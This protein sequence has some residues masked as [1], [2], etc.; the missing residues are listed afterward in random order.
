MRKTRKMMTENKKFPVWNQNAAAYR[1]KGPGLARVLSLAFVLSLILALA[2]PLPAFGVDASRT[3]DPV[4]AVVYASNIRQSGTVTI[5]MTAET[6]QARG[7]RYGDIVNVSF[8]GQTI[9]IPFCSSYGDVPEGSAVLLAIPGE[10]YL[11]LA[12]NGGDFTSTY[13]LAVKSVSGI[14]A[15]SFYWTFSD[16]RRDSAVITI[17]LEAAGLYL[18]GYYS[19]IPL[20]ISKI[21]EDFPDLTDAQFANFRPVTTTG[22]GRGVLYRTSSPVDPQNWRNTYADAE[23]RKAGVTVVLNLADSQGMISE[24]P[25]FGNSY[26][27]T[28]T[29]YG[30]AMDDNFSVPEL[31]SKIAE[32]LKF[33]AAHPG[34]YAVHCTIGRDRA[35]L[36]SALFECFMGASYHEIVADYMTTYYNY[37]GITPS[38]TRYQ[39]IAN[40][41]IVRTLTRLFEVPDLSQ[42]DLAYCAERY[43][44]TIGLTDDEISALRSNL[45]ASPAIPQ[46]PTLTN[47]SVSARSSVTV[48]RTHTVQNGEDLWSISTKYY[49][50]ARSYMRI[51]TINR[52]G[53]PYQIR[54]G[55]TLLIPV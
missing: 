5:S 36:I 16:G 47:A 30:L 44:R 32:G 14:H 40:S 41:N 2:F 12:I 7:Y 55:Q 53:Y 35:G 22:M 8:S 19:L 3:A 15:D 48:Y 10:N 29:Y 9:K 34:V 50:D 20:S 26:Y 6:F 11:Q 37:Y 39:A 4:E 46:P 38:E 24:Y 45:S 23:L 33:L 51:A 13:G 42:T 49:G 17:S 18:Q 52:I 28:I 54:V 27:S 25:G 31:P 21:R 1:I 43:F